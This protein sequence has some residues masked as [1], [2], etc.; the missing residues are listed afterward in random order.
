MIFNCLLTIDSYMNTVEMLHATSLQFLIK[1]IPLKL[2]FERDFLY[3][4][5]S[6]VS[7]R[8]KVFPH[9]LFGN[10]LTT[11]TL[12]KCV[13]NF[14]QVLDLKIF[15]LS[16]FSLQN[17]FGTKAMKEFYASNKNNLFSKIQIIKP[18]QY[19]LN[20]ITLIVIVCPFSLMKK[21][22]KIKTD[23]YF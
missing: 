12:H 18:I 1:K 22:E 20:K 2:I 11:R 5:K 10:L 15:L 14:K 7:N 4:L 21:N 13:S 3:P 6:K 17:Y 16:C 9:L 19:I 23:K 8:A